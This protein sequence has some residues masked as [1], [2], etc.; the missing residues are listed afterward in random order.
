MHFILGGVIIVA[1]ALILAT[2]LILGHMGSSQ[3]QDA[4]LLFLLD[5]MQA[6]PA[7]GDQAEVPGPLGLLENGF[8]ASRQETPRPEERGIRRDGRPRRERL[9]LQETPLLFVTTLRGRSL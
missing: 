4:R 6:F 8:A 3:R 5:P 9:P 2:W 7:S 1:A